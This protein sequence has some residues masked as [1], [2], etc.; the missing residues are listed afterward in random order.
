M[1]RDARKPDTCLLRSIAGL[2]RTSGNW[3]T[4]HGCGYELEADRTALPKRL[5]HQFSS[6]AAPTI[7]PEKPPAACCGESHRA[8]SRRFG[9]PANP[10]GSGTSSRPGD[11]RRGR[12]WAPLVCQG[13]CPFPSVPGEGLRCSDSQDPD[14]LRAAAPGCLYRRPEALAGQRGAVWRRERSMGVICKS[15]LRCRS[16][17]GCR[18]PSKDR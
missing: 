9:G 1:P 14:S 18:S 17:S 12:G 7:Y 4:P 15:R 2:G 6:L 10:Q 11:I 8:P 13:R 3:G 16:R 5:R